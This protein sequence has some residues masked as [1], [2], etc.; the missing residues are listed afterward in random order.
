MQALAGPRRESRYISA[1]SDGCGLITQRRSRCCSAPGYVVSQLSGFFLQRKAAPEHLICCM[2]TRIKRH[3]QDGDG[4][5]YQFGAL[6]QADGDQAQVRDYLRR[7]G[8]KK[9]INRGRCRPNRNAACDPHFECS[10]GNANF[11]EVQ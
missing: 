3:A 1:R 9:A 2:G 10:A 7:S 5:Y 8:L 4:K 6:A 11:S